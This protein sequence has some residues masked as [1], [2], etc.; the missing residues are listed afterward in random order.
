MFSVMI[1]AMSSMILTPASAQPVGIGVKGGINFSNLSDDFNMG[2]GRIAFSS[3][4][5]IVVGGYF[6]IRLLPVI[7]LQ[8]EVLYTEK[9]GDL[10]YA[11]SSENIIVFR[12]PLNGSL[13][14]KYIEVPVLIR[15]RVPVPGISPTVYA[16]PTIAFNIESTLDSGPVPNIDGFSEIDIEDYIKSMDFGFIVGAGLDFSTPVLQFN[17]EARY[18]LGLTDIDDSDEFNS[19]ARNNVASI[20]LGVTF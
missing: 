19:S 3:K 4:T 15:A 18:T 1:A 16:G 8:P 10:S 14:L 11:E 20:I 7:T 12:V 13:N 2:F 5:G 9:G 17:I 6:N